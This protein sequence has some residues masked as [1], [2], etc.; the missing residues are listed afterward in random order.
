MPK[1]KILSLIIFTFSLKSRLHCSF[2]RFSYK[3]ISF[4]LW[5]RWWIQGKFLNNLS[6]LLGSLFFKVFFGVIDF[7]ANIPGSILFTKVNKVCSR[8]GRCVRS[9]LKESFFFSIPVFVPLTDFPIINVK[10]VAWQ[11]KIMFD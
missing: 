5:M 2:F 8:C 3:I 11:R 7:I 1:V 4:C 9:P 10:I 6:H